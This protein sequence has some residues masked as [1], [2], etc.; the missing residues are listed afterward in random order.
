[1][2]AASKPEAPATDVLAELKRSASLAIFAVAAAAAAGSALAV[3][4]LTP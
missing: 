3:R 4:V 1:V 2:A